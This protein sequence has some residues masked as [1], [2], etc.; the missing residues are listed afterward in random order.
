MQSKKMGENMQFKIEEPTV[1]L[2]TLGRLGTADVLTPSTVR[3][4]LFLPQ[5]DSSVKL[6]F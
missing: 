4:P 6:K 1:W 2:G 5:R 3:L